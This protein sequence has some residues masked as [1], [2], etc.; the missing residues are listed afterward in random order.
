MIFVKKKDR[1][2]PN[3]LF[4]AINQNQTRKFSEDFNHLIN[5]PCMY[6]TQELR[7]RVVMFF[8]SYYPFGNNGNNF[9]HGNDIFGTTMEG[10]LGNILV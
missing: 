5:L 3:S 2:T 7:P 10:H 1:L 8:S 4:Y 9:L 6:R